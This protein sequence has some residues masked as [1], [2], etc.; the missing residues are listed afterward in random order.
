MRQKK[1]SN[2]SSAKRLQLEDKLDDLVSL[3][4][5]HTAPS[6]A[7]SSGDST[8]LTPPSLNVSPQTFSGVVA[9]SVLTEHQLHYFREHHL[10]YFPFMLLPHNITADHLQQEKPVLSLTIRTICTKA[11]SQQTKL[12]KL[13]RE[14]L[15]EKVFVNGE[16]SLDLLQG[17]I[18]CTAW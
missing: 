11:V 12:S 4:R 17:C 6:A 13:C 8:L 1:V 7:T 18:V 9:E 15:A 5:T 16:R 10:K 2:T 3:L 14:T